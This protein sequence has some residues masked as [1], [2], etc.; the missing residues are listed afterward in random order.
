ME[1]AGDNLFT[2]STKGPIKEKYQ[3]TQKLASG[4]FGIVYLA[5]DR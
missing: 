1:G 3:F 2:W 4:G 5:E